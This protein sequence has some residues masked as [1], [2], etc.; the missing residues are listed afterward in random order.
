MLILALDSTALSGSV[1]LCE[2]ESLIA[3]Y[4]VS[5]GHTHSETLL[6]MVEAVLK[7]AG[8]RVEEIGLFA[9][10]IGPGS[11]TGVRIG[12]AT[13]K[14]LA[15]GRDVPCVGVST[16][17]ALAENGYLTAARENALICPVMNAR[18][19]QVFHALFE[20][21][22]GHMHR[23]CDDRALPVIELAKELAS[24]P[25]YAGRA[26]ILTGDGTIMTRAALELALGAERIICLPERDLRVNAYHVAQCA[27]REYREGSYTTAAALTPVY[28]RMSQAERT[29]AEK[30]AETKHQNEE[31]TS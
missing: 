18:R 5:T 4:T 24:E 3:E 28:L 30:M 14:G 19:E 17:A 2:D 12:A 11:F 13:I 27:L 9:C 16:P 7:G 31:H 22:D 20:V 6:P 10:T 1:A 29:R 8:R 25:A 21:R 15:F 26:V 23:L